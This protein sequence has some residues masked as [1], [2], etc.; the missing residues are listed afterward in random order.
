MRGFHGLYLWLFR[1]RIS[2]ARMIIHDPTREAAW[3][4][5]YALFYIVAAVA[6]GIL[7]R[8]RPWP[9]LGAADFT[10]DFWYVVVFKIALL[11]IVPVAVFLRAGYRFTALLPEW[12][13]S[14]GSIF[15]IFLGAAVAAPADA[16]R[17]NQGR[18]PIYEI[19][20]FCTTLGGI[21]GFFRLTCQVV[22]RQAPGRGL[23]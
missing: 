7:I 19:R 18:H 11:L 12:R 1:Q 8:A 5:S 16:N 3:S 14:A 20:Q 13:A 6:T 15:T 10:Q 21:P 9:L 4:I 2:A 23:C 22:F 17:R